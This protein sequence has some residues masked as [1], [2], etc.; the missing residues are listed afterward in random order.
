M[1]VKPKFQLKAPIRPQAAVQAKKEEAADAP[2]P[3]DGFS[4]SA[5]Q[6][7]APSK[8][9]FEKS[10]PEPTKLTDNPESE[11]LSG[12]KRAITAGLVG[13]LGM[14]ALAGCVPSDPGSSTGEETAEMKVLHSQLAELT[15][16][17]KENGNQS[18]SAVAGGF[19]DS[20]A[21]Y[22]KAT[23]E[24]G[25]ELVET[26]RNAI[27]KHP[28]IAASL[29]FAGGTAIGISAD[30]LGVTDAA[31]ETASDVVNWVKENPAKAFGIGVLVAGGSYLAYQN[32]VK[33][34]LEV[35]EKPT[36]EQAEAMEVHFG[37]LEQ[38]LKENPNDKEVQAEVAKSLTGKIADYAKATGRSAVEVKNDVVAW[39][40]DHPILATSMVAGAGVATGVVLSRAGVPETVAQIAGTA[41][42]HAGGGFDAVVEYAKENPVVAGA[43]TAAV[44]AGAGYL[45]YQ[46]M[47]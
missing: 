31:M 26:M 44:A 18:N 28:Y 13:V 5:A 10:A 7:E 9:V 19:I 38:Q 12:W 39:A 11:G 21:Q 4:P 47:N 15:E 42:D 23:G 16:S 20:I 2:A 24:K 37:Q 14:G 45:I 32:L 30:Q 35:P 6:S 33:P 46:A 36:G 22:S 29:A 8:P 3:K 40:Y 25:E 27:R 41:I 1:Q 43:V 34:M 17:M